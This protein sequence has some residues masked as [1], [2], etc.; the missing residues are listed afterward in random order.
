MRLV[1]A[2]TLRTHPKNWRIH[3]ADQ[4]SALRLSLNRLGFTTALVVYDSPRYG[5]LT[6][7]DGHLRHEEL[8]TG[9]VPVLL[10]DLNDDEA[11]AVIASHD[12]IGQMAE[13]DELA[14]SALLDQMAGD[15]NLTELAEAL[16]IREASDDVPTEKDDKPSAVAYPIA[17][18]WDEGYNAIILVCRTEME[19]ARLKTLLNPQV[20]RDR[21]GS[22]GQTAV[23]FAN[24]VL[25][26]CVQRAQP[27]PAPSAK[28]AEPTPSEHAQAVT[29]D[30]AALTE[31]LRPA[32]TGTDL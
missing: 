26:R 4:R 19:W 23:M 30:L 13:T 2:A 8:A 24:D 29:E 17:P 31:E 32:A 5:G 15:A 12:A 10:T 25:E 7:I 27:A 16:T 11:D 21:K 1:D 22:L 28:P 6:I 3:G 18:N 9:D 20:M 14:L